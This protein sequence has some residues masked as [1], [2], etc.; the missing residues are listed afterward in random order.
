M[1]TYSLTPRSRR[2]LAL[3]RRFGSRTRSELIHQTGLSGTAVFRASEDL[4]AAGLV[5]TGDTVAR[6]RGQPSA[7]IH[8]VPDAAFSVGLSL[9]ADRADLL[10]L[11][12]AG[13]V[14]E[15]RE[16]SL[17]GMSRDAILDAVASFVAEQPIRRRIVGIGVAIAGFFT[18][19]GVT[20]PTPELDDWALVDLA[21]VI[22]DRIEL[23]AQVENIANAAAIGER[24]LGIGAD[25]DSFCYLNVGSGFRAG[26]VE[27]GQLSRG[28]Y[29]NAGEIAG[30]FHFAGLPTPHLGDLLQHLGHYGVH[31]VDIADLVRRFDPAWPGVDRWVADRSDAFAKIFQMLRYTL[32]CEA[33][34]LGGRLPRSLA[35]QLI[36]AISWP[37]FTLPARRGVRAPMTKLAVA[38]LTPDLAAPLGAASLVLHRALF[39]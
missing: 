35:Q 15:R 29:G 34:I 33:I 20:N 9:M 17:P 6:G 16:V 24:L 12:L 7:S 1:I 3:V 14:R 21:S 22:A 36:A 27:R 28:Y 32:D 39:D 8:I 37:E 5:R 10:L 13:N 26:I 38:E 4:E 11:D 19:P 25:Y 30:M 31:C 18:A 23:P 2:V